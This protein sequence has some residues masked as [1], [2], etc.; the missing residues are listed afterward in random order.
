[1]EE[2]IT[3]QNNTINN[4]NT[5]HKKEKKTNKF[6]LISFLLSI[7]SIIALVGL[8]I[9]YFF[10]GIACLIPDPSSLS[11]IQDTFNG[12]KNLIIIHST[13]LPFISIILGIIGLTQ[14]KKNLG[15]S[16]SGI[17]ISF[18]IL[19]T[20]ITLK[21]SFKKIEDSY[22]NLDYDSTYYDNSDT[23]FYY[24]DSTGIL[25]IENASIKFNIPSQYESNLS[26]ISGSKKIAYETLYNN[27]ESINA[28][29]ELNSTIKK[30]P[31]EYLEEQLLKYKNDKSYYTNPSYSSINKLNVNNNIFYYIT[32]KYTKTHGNK[33]H[34][35]AYNYTDIIGVYKL[36]NDCLYTIYASQNSETETNLD[37]NTI[38]DF[39][40]IEP[41]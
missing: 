26:L 2:N 16:I 32:I 3:I 1:M 4:Q 12:L 19:F 25:T 35:Y 6:N 5:I 24:T 20:A 18:I 30:E 10:L 23:T 38:Y 15:L 22:S 31:K 33:N 29:C 9:S 13:I 11:K 14:K 39:M 28:K 34:K 8:I 7:Y 41:Q 27:K 17:I 36:P 40:I 21:I 37:I